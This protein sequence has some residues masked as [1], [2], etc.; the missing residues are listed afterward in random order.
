M[1]DNAN[2]EVKQRIS[3][4][5]NIFKPLMLANLIPGWINGFEWIAA[6]WCIAH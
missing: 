6:T 3:D 2:W 4:M 5:S 1:K